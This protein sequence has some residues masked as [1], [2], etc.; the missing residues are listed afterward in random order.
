MRPAGRGLACPG[1]RAW[2]HAVPQRPPGTHE[3]AEHDTHAR[4]VCGES[5]ES[6][7]LDDHFDAHDADNDNHS[8][9]NS[10][11]NGTCVDNLDRDDD[12]QDDNPN[13][14]IDPIHYLHSGRFDDDKSIRDLGN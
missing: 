11:L 8:D 6:H 4:G 10:H 3:D 12:K 7:N 1:G 13:E 9:G 14:I 2:L 5:C